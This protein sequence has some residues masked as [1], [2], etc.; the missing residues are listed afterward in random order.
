MAQEVDDL[1]AKE[2]MEGVSKANG[3]DITDRF[4]NGFEYPGDKSAVELG[5]DYREASVVEARASQIKRVTQDK[6]KQMALNVFRCL[7]LGEIFAFSYMEMQRDKVCLH[8]T[9]NRLGEVPGDLLGEIKNAG[10]EMTGAGNIRALEIPFGKLDQLGI[11][12]TVLDDVT[13]VR[14]LV[15]SVSE[16]LVRRPLESCD[17]GGHGC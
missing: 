14:T 16:G 7:N 9:F 17:D 11:G 1:S 4:L 15:A 6:L 12:S 2:R 13:T 5:R 3:L 8:L 10:F